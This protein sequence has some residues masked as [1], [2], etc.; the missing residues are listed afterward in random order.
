M[1]LPGLTLLTLLATAPA[2]LAQQPAQPGSPIIPTPGN[3][4][5]QTQPANL[6]PVL[7]PQNRLDA[8]ML[9]WEER[10]KGVESIYATELTRTEKDKDGSIRV[11]RG[12]A[13][14]LKPN[15]AALRMIRQDNPSIFELYI[16]TGTFLY[17]FRPK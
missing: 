13:R 2:L 15:L 9:Q 10:M 16:C 6:V 8:L 3:G 14:Y 5:G 4:N 7:N 17:D 1:R 11:L 12:E